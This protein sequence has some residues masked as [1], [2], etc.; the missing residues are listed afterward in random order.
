MQLHGLMLGD[1]SVKRKELFFL[2]TPAVLGSDIFTPSCSK[3]G[4]L[5]SCNHYVTMGS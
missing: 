1:E 4:L 2:D 3:D 5:L